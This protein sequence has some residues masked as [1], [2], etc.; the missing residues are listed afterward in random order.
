MSDC[1]HFYS[2]FIFMVLGCFFLQKHCWMITKFKPLAKEN[3][4]L[5]LY[6]A[7]QIN[8]ILDTSKY[9]L[10]VD[11][12]NLLQKNI[13]LFENLNK[14]NASNVQNGTI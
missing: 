10:L 14:M 5:N 9:S 8:T 7:G 2:S 12:Q 6:S 4:T 11:S 1:D 13:L 3:I